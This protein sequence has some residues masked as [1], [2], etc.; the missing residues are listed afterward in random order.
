MALEIFWVDEANEGL[1]EII[2]HLEEKWTEK[3]IHRFF[4]RL[5]EC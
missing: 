4:T 3:E 2:G 1:D 5:E